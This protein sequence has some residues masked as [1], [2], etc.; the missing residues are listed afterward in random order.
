M[1]FFHIIFELFF[2]SLGVVS[3][4]IVPFAPAPS[5]YDKRAT[6]LS[7][8]KWSNTEASRHEVE[9]IQKKLGIFV[10]QRLNEYLTFPEK[11]WLSYTQLI[12]SFI[13]FQVF[14]REIH[15]A[16]V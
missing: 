9:D 5:L 3:P 6:S 16:Q 1:F 7:K 8:S 12:F 10:P 2:F 13:L 15:S 4:K 11:L 14:R